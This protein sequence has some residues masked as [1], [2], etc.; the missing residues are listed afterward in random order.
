MIIEFDRPV[1]TFQ[2]YSSPVGPMRLTSPQTKQFDAIVRDLP[3]RTSTKGSNKPSDLTNL[4]FLGDPSAVR[5]AFLAAGWSSADVLDAASTFESVRALSGTQTYDEA[6][7]STLLLDERPPVFTFQ[8]TTNTFASRHHT[9]VFATGKTFDRQTVLTASSTQDVAIAFSSR[10]KTFIHVIDQDI[11]NERSKI[12]NDLIFTGCVESIELVQRPWLPD[13]AYNSTGDRLVTDG[14][15]PVLQFNDCTNPRTTPATPAMRPPA[16]E[17]GER[18]FMLSLKDTL[19]RG[20]VI[21]GGISGGQKAHSYFASRGELGEAPTNWRKSDASGTQYTI[22]EKS[23]LS[24]RVPAP[25]DTEQPQ[26]AD[27][28]DSISLAQIEAHRWDPPRFEIGINLGY[29]RYRTSPLEVTEV[30]LISSNNEEPYFI[31]LNDDVYDGWAAGATVTIN[32]WNWI[33]N[34]FS[35]AREQTK[36][37]LYELEAPGNPNENISTNTRTVGLATRRFAY[38][39]VLNLRP[40]KSRWRPYFTA[41]PAFQLIALA[42]APLKKPSGFFVLGASNIGLIVSAFDF[43]NTPPLNGGGIFQFG[44]QY[45]AGFKYRVLPRLTMRVDYGE[46]WS[47]TPKIIRDSYISYEPPGLDNTYSTHVGE[48]LNPAK[49]VQQHATAGFAFTF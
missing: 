20:N 5:R 1:L 32:S 15:A 48:F 22:Y 36:F 19:Y 44:L 47:Q 14:D 42:D 24:H 6:P 17:R 31:N 7:M 41:G 30:L 33:S 11:D 16:L 3:Y 27:K 12:T 38:N 13:D 18:D 45:G 35:Y 49:Y 9:R 43:G 8:K 28:L 23:K 46:T 39:S 37:D 25:V 21:Y 26:Q 40:R 4:I 10:Q 34:E 2:Q 29:S